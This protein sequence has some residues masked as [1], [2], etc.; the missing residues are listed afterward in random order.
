MAR[1]SKSATDPNIAALQLGAPQGALNLPPPVRK[2]SRGALGG[3]APRGGR[4]RLPPAL[5]SQ[6]SRGG[7]KAKRTV[8]R[9]KGK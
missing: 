6:G 8:A 5:E 3:A 9:K 4:T 7:K 1:A 2:P